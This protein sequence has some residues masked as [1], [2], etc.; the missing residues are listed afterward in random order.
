MNIAQRVVCPGV[1]AVGPDRS[2]GSALGEKYRCGHVGPAH[3]STECVAG[4]KHA[5]CLAIVWIDR[6]CFLKQG[7]RDHVVLP[8]QTPIVRQ[9]AHD[10]IPGV[11]AV[12]SLALGTEVFCSVKLR[13]NSADNSLR[14]LVLNR[15]YVGNV[16]VI[17]FCPD[18]AAGCD[19]DELSG[20]AYALT[21][22]PYAALDDIADPEF[23]ADLFQMDG[24]ALV[25]E[26][27]VACDYEEPAQF[28]QRGYD[29]FADAVGEIFLFRLA[30]HVEERQ[31]RN[32]RPVGQRQRGAE[33]IASVALW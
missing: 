9:S 29:V 11:H 1:L 12:R 32:G 19:I 22:L 20:D 3:M 17:A 24:L 4:G 15:E 8:R 10:E 21:F 5:K 7:L 16:A 25:S 13:F 27:R 26:G 14:Y 31:H 33:G 23:F 6:G 28:R 2:H 30:A 18:M